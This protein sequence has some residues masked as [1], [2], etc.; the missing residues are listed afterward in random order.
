MTEAEVKTCK[1]GHP[2]VEENLRPPTAKG[3]RACRLCK[4]L[5][6]AKRRE[7]IYTKPTDFRHY[8]EG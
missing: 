5:S 1:R 8:V 2:Q 6:D 3:V 4:R 7:E